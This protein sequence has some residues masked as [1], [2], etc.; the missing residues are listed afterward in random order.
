MHYFCSKKKKLS[1]GDAG[2]SLTFSPGRAASL[3][4]PGPDGPPQVARIFR[5]GW[6]E[7]EDRERRE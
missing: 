7:L 1:T 3:L 5:D 2:V 6:V 4:A